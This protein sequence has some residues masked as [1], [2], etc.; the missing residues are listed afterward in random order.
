MACPDFVDPHQAEQKSL[1]PELSR[2]AKKA[3]HKGFGFTGT[4]DAVE[5]LGSPGFRAKAHGL[6]FPELLR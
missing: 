3:L 6:G 4:N 1:G 2:L 5:C